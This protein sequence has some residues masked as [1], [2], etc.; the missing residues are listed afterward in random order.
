L[1]GTRLALRE[2][3]R[4]RARFGLLTGAVGLLAFLI[5]FQQ[6]ILTS[7]VT[8]F[9]GAIRNQSAPVL[10]Y[11][12]DARRNIEGSRVSDDTITTIRRVPGVAR[13]EHIGEGTFTVT[14][15]GTLHDAVLFGYEIGGLGAPT[16]LTSGRLPTRDGEA[17]ASDLDRNDGFDIG[18]R[19][20]VEPGG[21]E[22][23]VVG[24][25]RDLRFSVAPTLFLSYDTY[26]RARLAANPDA[27]EVI[28]SLGAVT[29][30]A[31][32]SPGEIARRITDSIEGTEA[33]DRGRA[34]SESPGVSA[35]QQSLG[36]V[37]LLAYIVVTLVTGF[38]F[39]ILTVQKAES[40]TLLRAVGAPGGYLVRALLAQV[41]T[42]VA[43]GVLVGVVLLTVTARAMQGGVA[44]TVE[45]RRVLITAAVVL[46]LSTLASITA[47][48]RVLRIEPVRATTGAGVEYS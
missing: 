27:T 31:G 8:Q 9:V 18:D 21:P 26:S 20:R 37:L 46:A 7:L 33:L 47:A 44:I 34:A 40:L 28:P 2:V 43:G 48:R 23:T 41:V 16:T 39:M 45:P 6:T 1:A 24:L 3:R 42:V 25:A 36:I 5:L 29:P 32:V 19:I 10:V 17:V 22:I 14:T 4:G 12:A 30:E 13:A 38:F 15:H 11:G 35:V